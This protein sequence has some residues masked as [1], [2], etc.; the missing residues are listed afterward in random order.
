MGEL[1]NRRLRLLNAS[2]QAMA[3]FGYLAGYRYAHHAMADPA[4]GALVREFMSR[5]AA[6]SL[7]PI[8]GVSFDAYQDELVERFSN[9]RVADTLSRLCADTSNRIPKW[10]VPLIHDNLANHRDVALS[11][12]IVA[13]WCR[14]S[15]GVDEAGDPIESRIGWHRFSWPGRRQALKTSLRSSVTQTY[16]VTFPEI[17]DSPSRTAEL[18][19]N[20]TREVRPMLRTLCWRTG[21]SGVANSVLGRRFEVADHWTQ[22]RRRSLRSNAC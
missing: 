9:P 14:Y 2:H 15:E 11:V 6:P 4:I 12:A 16:S 1:W 21:R 19:E 13:S 5:E 10:L 7:A 17:S 8:T 20:C 3:Y 22:L 18:C